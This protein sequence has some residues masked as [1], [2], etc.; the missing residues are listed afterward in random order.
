MPPASIE[1]R[2]AEACDDG[3]NLRQV[4]VG[5]LGEG[6]RG[7][8]DPANLDAFVDVE[9]NGDDLG[10]ESIADDAPS[11]SCSRRARS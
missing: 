10:V 4:A 5:L 7:L 11:R 2:H 6:N 8:A 9:R 3:P 1:R